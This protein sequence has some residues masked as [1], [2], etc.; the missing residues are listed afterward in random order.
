M[1]TTKSLT[2]TQRVVLS[3]ASMR[4]DGAVLPVPGSV[5]LNP[6][7]VR[8]VLHSLLK[9]ALVQEVPAKRDD[10]S[11]RETDAG[12]RMALVISDEGCAAIGVDA[13]GTG[14][15]TELKELQQPELPT[16]APMAAAEAAKPPA[17]ASATIASQPKDGT[18]LSILIEAL[19]QP[20]GATIEELIVVTGWQAH[21]IRGAMSGALKKDRGLVVTSEKLDQRGRVYRLPDV[22]SKIVEAGPSSSP[23]DTVSV[24]DEVVL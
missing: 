3:H 4:I 9:Q 16:I 5:R 10:I 14:P 24:A 2:D 12:D 21:S 22:A 11:W 17:A 23:V 7:A 8:V 20:S 6:G 18:K 13:I 19:S 1:T 15:A